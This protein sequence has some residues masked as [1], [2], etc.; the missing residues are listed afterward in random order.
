VRDQLGPFKNSRITDDEIEGQADPFYAE[1]RAFG[2]INESIQ[3]GRKK[4]IAVGCHGFLSIPA[5][6]EE[7]F[8]RRFDIV[9]WDR[10]EDWL[11]DLT[12]RQPF[13]AIVKDLILEDTEVTEK[14]IRTMRIELKALNSLKIYVKDISRTNYKGGHIVDFSSAWTYPHFMFRRDVGDQDEIESDKKEDLW[15]F[16]KMVQEEFGLQ[17]SVRTISRPGGEGSLR[18]KLRSNKS[19][20][21]VI[22]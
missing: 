1:C 5:D 8:A 6:K 20:I 11:K 16:D 9:D 22:Q 7:F 4:P 15:L 19:Y 2:R 12:Q 17:I 3:K 18:W 21:S 14:A 13:R 10:P